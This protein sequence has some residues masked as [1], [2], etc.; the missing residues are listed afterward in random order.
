MRTKLIIALL[1]TAGLAAADEPKQSNEPP[2][3]P[4]QVT[5]MLK[6][7]TGTWQCKG[8]GYMP[9]GSTM[10]L[11]GTNTAKADLNGFWIHDHITVTAKPG[12]ESKSG[13]T[14]TTQPS[15]TD[16]GKPTPGTDS[17]TSGRATEGTAKHG[18]RTSP[19]NLTI[20]Q[21]TTYDA[22]QNKWRRV[23]VDSYGGQAVGTAD[24]T[25]DNKSQEFTLDASG[26]MGPTQMREK[27]DMTDA[28]T[29]TITGERS[30]DQGKTWN[31][32]Y[33]VTCTK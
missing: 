22:Q 27:T 7:R 16:T 6:S 17:A 30:L 1:G 18:M 9:D 8:T 19:T 31:K 14:E 2:T 29:V 24:T 13:G 26:P 4:Q 33:Q 15:D 20:D 5:D 23:S 28:K 12:T 32:D 25:G 3:K 10:K 21:F 11:T